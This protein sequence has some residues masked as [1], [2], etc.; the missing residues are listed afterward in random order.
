MAEPEV[1]VISISNEDG[2]A[3]TISEE[4]SVSFGFSDMPAIYGSLYA[5]RPTNGSSTTSRALA[6]YLESG[7]RS[8]SNNREN[9]AS[10]TGM[11]NVSLT[12]GDPQMVSLDRRAFQ[13]SCGEI[14][15]DPLATASG[16]TNQSSSSTTI[17]NSVVRETSVDDGI[18]Y[19]T[20]VVPENLSEQPSPSMSSSHSQPTSSRIGFVGALKRPRLDLNSRIYF[21]FEALSENSNIADLSN[22]SAKKAM[23]VEI[24]DSTG[25]THLPR[26]SEVDLGISRDISAEGTFEMNAEYENER[27]LFGGS[28][29]YED[30]DTDSTS[31]CYESVLSET[32]SNVS[33]IKQTGLRKRNPTLPSNESE[34]ANSDRS[35][36]SREPM[37]IGQIELGHSMASSA[38]TMVQ[39]PAIAHTEIEGDRSKAMMQ[40]EFRN[41]LI[42]SDQNQDV[43]FRIAGYGGTQN[44]E[45]SFEVIQNDRLHLSDTINTVKSHTVGG[46]TNQSSSKSGVDSNAEPVYHVA[47]QQNLGFDSEEQEEVE[48]GPNSYEMNSINIDHVSKS[49]L[50]AS[51]DKKTSKESLKLE[52]IPNS[53]PASTYSTQRELVTPSKQMFEEP[54][55]KVAQMIYNEE[56]SS[57]GMEGGGSYEMQSTSIDHISKSGAM[58]HSDLTDTRQLNVMLE[59]NTASD[60]NAQ[61]ESLSKTGERSSSIDATG[62]FSSA[63]SDATNINLSWNDSRVAENKVS[64]VQ[65]DQVHKNQGNE[66]EVKLDVDSSENRQFTSAFSDSNLFTS[67][68]SDAQQYE[69]SSHKAKT[70]SEFQQINVSGP[71]DKSEFSNLEAVNISGMTGANSTYSDAR[72]F[73]NSRTIGDSEYSDA[74]QLNLSGYSEKI[75]FSDAQQFNHSNTVGSSSFSD[76]RQYN[77]SG[78]TGYSDYSDAYQIEVSLQ[79]ERAKSG[80]SENSEGVSIQGD[81]YRPSERSRVFAPDEL[82]AQNDTPFS[83]DFGSSLSGNK[84]SSN[85]ESFESGQEGDSQL[86]FSVPREQI[87]SSGVPKNSNS[88]EDDTDWSHQ[89]VQTAEEAY[90]HESGENHSHIHFDYDDASMKISETGTKNDAMESSGSGNWYEQYFDSGETKS[91]FILDSEREGTMSSKFPLTLANSDNTG[92]EDF[93]E[94]VEFNEVSKNAQKDAPIVEDEH[95]ST[96]VVNSVVTFSE[97]DCQIEELRSAT[98][99][100]EESDTN[101]I[102]QHVEIGEKSNIVSA[103]FEQPDSNNIGVGTIMSNNIQLMGLNESSESCETDRVIFERP[104]ACSK[105]LVHVNTDRVQGYTSTQSHILDSG[106]HEDGNQSTAQEVDSEMGVKV[107]ECEHFRHEIEQSNVLEE[108]STQSHILDSE[109]HE[110]CNQSTVEEVESEVEVKIEQREHV[111]DEIE[112]SNVLEEISFREN[113]VEE[114]DVSMEFDSVKQRENSSVSDQSDVNTE[115]TLNSA[116]SIEDQNFLESTGIVITKDTS[117]EAAYALNEENSKKLPM[118]DDASNEAYSCQA[119][120]LAASRLDDKVSANRSVSND[121]YH[122]ATSFLAEDN[123]SVAKVEPVV[124]EGKTHRIHIRFKND[125]TCLCHNLEVRRDLI[126]GR[127]NDITVQRNKDIAESKTES[128]Q[129]RFQVE[130]SEIEKSVENETVN[131]EVSN[132]SENLQ[133]TESST[134]LNSL[135]DETKSLKSSQD[136]TKVNEILIEQPELSNNKDI[137][138]IKID[139]AVKEAEKI[140]LI[141]RNAAENEKFEIEL[142]REN[143]SNYESKDYVTSC[144]TYESTNDSNLTPIANKTP[145]A[146][147][148]QELVENE[149][150]NERHEQIA[151]PDLETVAVKNHTR[152]S[153]CGSSTNLEPQDELASLGKVE[154]VP[155]NAFSDYCSDNFESSFVEME[156]DLN[157]CNHYTSQSAGN[158]DSNLDLSP[159]QNFEPAPLTSPRSLN[160]PRLSK[161]NVAKGCSA[162]NRCICCQCSPCVEE[163]D[164][165]QCCAGAPIKAEDAD[166]FD[167][168]SEA[169]LR[170]MMVPNRA[171]LRSDTPFSDDETIET[172]RQVAPISPVNLDN[173]ENSE[174]RINNTEVKMVIASNKTNLR[175]NSPYDDQSDLENTSD[176]NTKSPLTA[177]N[178]ESFDDEAEMQ[179]VLTSNR[180]ETSEKSPSYDDSAEFPMNSPARE[181]IEAED[182][183]EFENR[184]NIEYRMSLFSNQT[185]TVNKSFDSLENE[186]TEACKSR[187]PELAQDLDSFEERSDTELKVDI[188]ANHIDRPDQNT[189]MEQNSAETPASYESELPVSVQDI[190]HFDDRSDADMQIVMPSNHVKAAMETPEASEVSSDIIMPRQVGSPVQADNADSFDDLS[191]PEVQMKIIANRTQPKASTSNVEEQS[192]EVSMESLQEQVPKVR[193]PDSTVASLKLD[194]EETDVTIRYHLVESEQDQNPISIEHKESFEYN[195]QPSGVISDSVSKPYLVID[196]SSMLSQ[197]SMHFSSIDDSEGLGD[198]ALEDFERTALTSMQMDDEG[199]LKTSFDANTSIQS[200][201]ATLA[202]QQTLNM[203]EVVDADSIQDVKPK[204]A[205]ELSRGDSISMEKVDSISSIQTFPKSVYEEL[206]MATVE[207]QQVGVF[208]NAHQVSVQP[209]LPDSV[210]NNAIG[211]KELNRVDY[212]TS[213]SE[214]RES[215]TPVVT[216]KTATTFAESKRVEDLTSGDWKFESQNPS[217]AQSSSYSDENYQESKDE[218]STFATE[219]SYA[220]PPTPFDEQVA[221]ADYEIPSGVRHVNAPVSYEGSISP[222]V[223]ETSLACQKSEVASSRSVPLG[224]RYQLYTDYSEQHSVSNSVDKQSEAFPFTP[225]N[226]LAST[227]KASISDSKSVASGGE[228]ATVLDTTRSSFVRSFCSS[229]SKTCAGGTFFDTSSVVLSTVGSETI[230]RDDTGSRLLNESFVEDLSDKSDAKATQVCESVMN[231]SIE[232]EEAVSVFSVMDLDRERNSDDESDGKQVVLHAT[233]EGMAVFMTPYESLVE[234]YRISEYRRFSEPDVNQSLDSDQ[235]HT[236]T[237]DFEESHFAVTSADDFNKSSEH[238]TEVNKHF[239]QK[240]EI[241]VER[242]GDQLEVCPITLSPNPTSLSS[243]GRTDFG[244]MV[245]CAEH[246]W[247]SANTDIQTYHTAQVAESDYSAVPKNLGPRNDQAY[248]PPKTASFTTERPP[249]PAI[250]CGTSSQSSEISTVPDDFQRKANLGHSIP[251][252]PSEVSSKSLDLTQLGDLDNSLVKTT[253]LP[254]MSSFP[255]S[256]D[257][258]SYVDNLLD[259]YGMNEKE[260]VFLSTVPSTTMPSN[261]D[262]VITDSMYQPQTNY[263]VSSFGTSEYE[264]DQPPEGDLVSKETS[265]KSA[266]TAQQFMPSNLD[267]VSSWDINAVM[268]AAEHRSAAKKKKHSDES[269]RATVS[270]PSLALKRSDPLIIQEIPRQSVVPRNSQFSERH[271]ASTFASGSEKHQETK[272]S[273]FS[274]I[275]PP[276]DKMSLEY[277][278][279]KLGILNKDG[280]RKATQQDTPMPVSPDASDERSS[281]SEYSDTEPSLDQPAGPSATNT[282]ADQLYQSAKE[283]QTSFS[284]YSDATDES[285]V[286]DKS[287]LNVTHIQLD[288]QPNTQS[289]SYATAHETDVLDESNDSPKMDA[290]KLNTE[291]QPDENYETAM[292]FIEPNTQHSKGGNPRAELEAK[293]DSLSQEQ[294]EFRTPTGIDSERR[295]LFLEPSDF[296]TPSCVQDSNQVKISAKDPNELPEVLDSDIDDEREVMDEEPKGFQTPAGFVTPLDFNGLYSDGIEDSSDAPFSDSSSFNG[297]PIPRS[298]SMRRFISQRLLEEPRQEE[299][300]ALEFHSA[301]RDVN[302]PPGYELTSP[303]SFSC[304]D[305]NMPN[306]KRATLDSKMEPPSSLKTATLPLHQNRTED[307]ARSGN[308]HSVR[309]ASLSHNAQFECPNSFQSGAFIGRDEASVSY[310][311][312][313]CDHD[314]TFESQCEVVSP[315]TMSHSFNC[316]LYGDRCEDAYSPSILSMSESVCS[317][318]NCDR[319]SVCSS[320]CSDPECRGDA[321]SPVYFANE[322]RQPRGSYSFTTTSPDYDYAIRGTS[323]ELSESIDR[324]VN[325]NNESGNCPNCGLEVEDPPVVKTQ[326]RTQQPVIATMDVKRRKAK[327]KTAKHKYHG[328]TGK[329]KR[330]GTVKRPPAYALNADT[331]DSFQAAPE[332]GKINQEANQNETIKKPRFN[333]FKWSNKCRLFR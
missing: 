233:E 245:P 117:F 75:D 63:L 307:T 70:E 147:Y 83:S 330:I 267:D 33:F 268:A 13:S 123:E 14:S 327:P 333:F 254:S 4:H 228:K 116:A 52:T 188:I 76:A 270:I 59:S 88:Y 93:H 283:Q 293:R 109:T 174:E 5:A 185:E 121:T 164:E 92:V 145:R 118:T 201:Y 137:T 247:H 143:Q 310:M 277:W 155:S 46:S 55:V 7:N 235:L 154:T 313:D 141:E 167:E 249:T 286:E 229:D 294:R 325:V 290:L 10:L 199:C 332:M 189:T 275:T 255:E 238:S 73:T 179:I 41:Q 37:N 257:S 100:H 128:S 30:V 289:L 298:D 331:S 87:N 132:V 136:S 282:T 259:A 271:P 22:R 36:R 328:H 66:R 292:E 90:I 84:D 250:P 192:C 142:E 206:M 94:V 300:P 224:P 96:S 50:E 200:S 212:S 269:L 186:V 183:D 305:S 165:N 262:D 246:G 196:D 62:Q 264:R 237:T 151:P 243:G 64:D 28:R 149:C 225:G 74:P 301:R 187:T 101:A 159:L 218:I 241:S 244:S 195:D 99:V 207:K 86:S 35:S 288:R 266:Y 172:V 1:K 211:P 256:E 303:S 280:S 58:D 54:I 26:I 34:G 315:S 125:V 231:S 49:A 296:K 24:T 115:M 124:S 236:P 240:Q 77:L 95:S 106:T 15:K 202:E 42:L 25:A 177:K 193:T 316:P 181:M 309:V 320:C 85:I 248:V 214:V 191:N 285:K 120:V 173:V 153:L 171:D 23:E 72:Q 114:H 51:L 324:P 2:N 175:T 322:Y 221:E 98:S 158:F 65:K 122:T 103:N 127:A 144:A 111:R 321:M 38:H 81:T 319:L 107:V 29:S 53:E 156:N 150:G 79:E 170:M 176:Q 97:A 67:D 57:I 230:A 152:G 20:L 302:P 21:D 44:I 291:R 69:V 222:S 234:E 61:Q 318:A 253:M 317:D 162:E 27:L 45:N 194:S 169:D 180:I 299:T 219:S 208:Q 306:T 217:L 11:S 263:Q 281:N 16:A 119:F 105:E 166:D 146:N 323:Y 160:K 43:S 129:N 223:V 209:S 135:T 278:R 31:R 308:D 48:L 215:L 226:S 205:N 273:T 260:V 232:Q 287:L 161:N 216:E 32:S 104:N 261:D 148:T 8:R 168:R 80:N 18:S 71:V 197:D 131:S 242:S 78:A 163:A 68:F 40:R 140:E 130:Q 314:P 239:V 182:V 9:Y 113:R 312:C 295:R 17:S 311:Y 227:E 304:S 184:S 190:D 47:Q 56:D 274:T 126:V 326:T 258:C 198:F 276:S 139:V 203:E 272:T 213:A 252:V 112:K 134:N 108:T 204:I 251:N 329:T 284:Y 3:T 265:M 178:V 6:T 82:S 110:D 138:D 12:E 220:E 297:E 279:N 39:E 157:A 89:R 133:K 19:D 91:E 102:L 210:L 60:T